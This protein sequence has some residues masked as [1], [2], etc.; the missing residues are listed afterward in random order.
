MVATQ[1]LFI[2]T[3]KTWGNSIQF[4]LCIFFKW[5]VKPPTR[6]P[7]LLVGWLVVVTVV[8]CRSFCRGVFGLISH[9]RFV[10]A[11]KHL[12]YDT[13]LQHPKWFD[14]SKISPR[15]PLEHTRTDPQPRIDVQ[16]LKQQFMSFEIGDAWVAYCIIQGVC[17]QYF[18]QKASFVCW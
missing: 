4:D 2:S 9:V 10:A 5:L 8:I 11:K 18:D 16:R 13:P 3:K 6:F 17:F 15:Y 7:F 12:G 14:F 1:A